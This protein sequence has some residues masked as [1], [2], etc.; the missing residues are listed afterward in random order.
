M[1]QHFTEAETATFQSPYSRI[2]I[3]AQLEQ[4]RD[5]EERARTSDSDAVIAK[6]R[7]EILQFRAGLGPDD[8]TYDL[9]V[10][11]VVDNYGLDLLLYCEQRLA[12]HEEYAKTFLTDFLNK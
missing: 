6:I 1:S 2:D 9:I 12:G 5:L 8:D 7:D 3:E 10:D 11:R 4:L